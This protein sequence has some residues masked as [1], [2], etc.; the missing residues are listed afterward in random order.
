M[1]MYDTAYNSCTPNPRKNGL[2]W[3]FFMYTE[4]CFENV[5]QNQTGALSDM[6]MRT[7]VPD[8]SLDTV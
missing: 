1:V 5:L 6:E 4:S 8:L 3:G 7:W 2:D